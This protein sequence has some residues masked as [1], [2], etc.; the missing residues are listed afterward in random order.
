MQSVG[1]GGAWSRL[2]SPL[3]RQD[4]FAA[5]FSEEHSVCGAE[6]KVKGDKLEPTQNVL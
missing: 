1:G 5:P 3:R 6:N 4:A 2:R